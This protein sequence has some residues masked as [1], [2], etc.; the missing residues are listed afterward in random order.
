MGLLNTKHG[1]SG[2]VA[3]HL[4]DDGLALVA[5]DRQGAVHAWRWLADSGLG[6]GGLHDSAE[7]KSLV[8]EL[9]LNGWRASVVL[10]ARDYQ[11]LL[12][13]APP[14]PDE[15]MAEAL[16]WRVR[17]LVDFDIT[18]ALLD[19]A[20][21]PED[22]YHGRTRMLYVAVMPAERCNELT[23]LLQQAQLVPDVIDIPELTLHNL[24]P[25]LQGEGTL[26]R[27]LVY[28]QE[29]ASVINLLADQSLYL[30]RRLETPMATLAAYES[31]AGSTA[32][33][34]IL[35]I[36]RSLDYYES[37][38]GKPPCMT[39]L[40]CPLQFGDAPLL[41]QLQDNLAVSVEQ[42]DVFSLLEVKVSPALPSPTLAEQGHLLV[43]LAAA[44]R[45]EQ[46][47]SSLKQQMNL[48]VSQVPAIAAPAVAWGLKHCAAVVLAVVLLLAGVAVYQS[49]GVDELAQQAALLE[50]EAASLQQQRLELQAQQPVSVID[51]R[52]A[53]RAALQAEIRAKREYRETLQ[54]LPTRQVPPF[55]QLLA[56][57]GQLNAE[58][59]SS[60]W[61]LNSAH[62]T[63]SEQR[64][65]LHGQ[66]SAADQLTAALMQLGDLP[67]YRQSRFDDLQL[68]RRHK[69]A[70]AATYD[71]SVAVYF[72]DISAG[73]EG[74][75]QTLPTGAASVPRESA[76]VRP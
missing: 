38:I 67:A 60:A 26:G 7:L 36:Q 15:E 66:L 75:A 32:M 46:R 31:E 6:A 53:E 43:A 19:Y 17:E 42:L 69:A 11:L 51:P 56:G 3:L 52:Q 44:L 45:Q 64:L 47:P 22:A 30:T 28:L 25:L 40:V 10:P 48:A 39:L 59:P 76:E 24:T 8:D 70:P 12:I 21:L 34:L 14:V 54:A 68:Q 35:D 72:S 1:N 29:P 58:H 9:G 57:L 23:A 49:Q 65:L 20:E 74:S 5:V 16:R 13:E 37:Q 71:F 33:P 73:S 27:A 55:S 50:A 2:R 18:E 63:A 4:S 41:R 61:T 62:L